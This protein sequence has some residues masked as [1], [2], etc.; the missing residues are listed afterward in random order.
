MAFE[1]RV[2][3]NSGRDSG[4]VHA[5]LLVSNNGRVIAI[6]NARGHGDIGAPYRAIADGLDKFIDAIEAAGS[7]AEEHRDDPPVDDPLRVFEWSDR[8]FLEGDGLQA[9]GFEVVAL[10]PIDHRLLGAGAAAVCAD[11]ELSDGDEAIGI[12]TS[13]DVDEGSSE[14]VAVF[15]RLRD[16]IR[17][18]LAA[19]EEATEVVKSWQEPEEKG[20]AE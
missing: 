9:C 17:A 10:S 13:F 16:A 7:A 2:F 15:S 3:V 6:G 1:A 4:T 19:I 12:S 11:I 5:E 14:T 18:M 8:A 20:K